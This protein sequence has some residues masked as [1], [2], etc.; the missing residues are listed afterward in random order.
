MNQKPPTVRI[1]HA[2]QRPQ[3]DPASTVGWRCGRVNGLFM[4]EA[5][6]R[7]GPGDGKASWN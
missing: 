7:A 3:A 4:A 2:I 6:Y 1:A 5:G